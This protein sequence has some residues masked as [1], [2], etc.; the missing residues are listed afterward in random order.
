M[1][2]GLRSISVCG[3]NKRVHVRS[4]AFKKQ[5]FFDAYFFNDLSILLP[6]AKIKGVIA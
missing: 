6:R 3:A 2:D 5:R 4:F 1:S